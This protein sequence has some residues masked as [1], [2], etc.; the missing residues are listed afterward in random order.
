MGDRAADDGLPYEDAV[1]KKL[2]LPAAAVAATLAFLDFRQ[3]S[4][5]APPHKPYGSLPVHFEPASAAGTFVSR[6]RGF[7]LELGTTGAQ[8]HLTRGTASAEVS[9]AAYAGQRVRLTL[10]TESG[11][12]GDVTGDWAGWERPR[13]IWQIP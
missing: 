1:M 2:L 12:A 11:P 6:G 9:L 3:E 4:P 13:L 8:V 10:R 7:A 5:P